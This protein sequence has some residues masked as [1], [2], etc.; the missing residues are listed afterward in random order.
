MQAKPVILCSV[1]GSPFY[2]LSPW[3]VAIGSIAFLLHARKAPGYPGRILHHRKST[4]QKRRR[5]RPSIFRFRHDDDVHTAFT[6]IAANQQRPPHINRIDAHRRLPVLFPL[7]ALKKLAH[8]KSFN[9]EISLKSFIM[10]G[11]VGAYQQS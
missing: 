5:A 10:I 4:S 7:F 1:T 9:D 2:T 3:S 8:S 6:T 11:F